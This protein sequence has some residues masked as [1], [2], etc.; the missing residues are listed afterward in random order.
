MPDEPLGPPRLARAA[1]DRAALHREDAA[2]LA[3]AWRRARVLVISPDATTPVERG[4]GAV[5]LALRDPSTVDSGAVRRLLGVVDG[6]PYF[7]VTVSSEDATGWANLREVGAAADDL[8]A[9]LLT[10]AVALEQWH[11]RH[12][13][14]PRCGAATEEAQAGWIRVCTSDGSQHFPRTDPAVIMLVHD[15]GDLCLLGRGLQ[16]GEKRFSTLAGFVEPGE[17]LEAAVAREVFEEV[18]VS[19]T[20]VRYI[21]SQPW[22][23]PSSLMVGFVARLDGDPSL[24]LDPKEMAEAHWF[25]RDEVKQASGWVDNGETPDPDARIHGVSPS[26]SIS[27]YLI[28]GWLARRW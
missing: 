10:S 20:D 13:R 8:P 17:S 9:A 1:Y 11:A 25:T 18:G 22:P 12:V 16:W 26:L 24:H 19:V 14:C 6:V 3:D 23:F 21:A 5:R 15:G 2:W 7:T 4:D 27:R 28:D